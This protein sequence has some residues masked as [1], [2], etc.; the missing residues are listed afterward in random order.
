M[1]DSKATTSINTGQLFALLCFMAWSEDTWRSR[2]MFRFHINI[3]YSCLNCL[4]IAFQIRIWKFSKRL[5]SFWLTKSHTHC[6]KSRS[7]RVQE[8]HMTYL[9]NYVW[10]WLVKSPIYVVYFSNILCAKSTHAI[11]V[12][13]FFDMLLCKDSGS[14]E[15]STN[16]LLMPF[17]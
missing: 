10:P 6:W 4:K 5:V 11:Y 7:A 3:S 16:I 17:I 13:Y 8:E 1:A 15:L 14:E 2:N 9:P 12:V